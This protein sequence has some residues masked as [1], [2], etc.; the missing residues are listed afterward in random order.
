[1]NWDEYNWYFDKSKAPIDTTEGTPSDPWGT[2]S[3]TCIGSACC[4]EGSTYDV[5]TNICVPNE[6]YTEQ[7]PETT[8]ETTT[9]TETFKG[10]SKYGYKQIKSS[11]L[12]N[13][14]LPSYSPLF[15][16]KY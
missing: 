7:N 13:N 2:P 16:I 12:N 1:M 10:L 15:K 14:I 5:N 8:T 9:V 4:Y 3:V 6:I 11:S